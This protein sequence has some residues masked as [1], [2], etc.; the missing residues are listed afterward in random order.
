MSQFKGFHLK[1]AP[2][3]YHYRESCSFS[4]QESE[5]FFLNA[6]K[7]NPNAAS[8]HGNLGKSFIRHVAPYWG[9][10]SVGCFRYCY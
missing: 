1:L 7:I 6:L 8:C 2:E 5:G 4:L 10:V 3:I 9:S